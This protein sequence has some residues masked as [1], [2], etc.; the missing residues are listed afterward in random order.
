MSMIKRL[1]T[2]LLLLF[3]LSILYSVTPVFAGVPLGCG[4]IGG[5]SSGDDCTLNANYNCVAITEID[6]PG[7]FT[8][9]NGF[10][11]N[12]N[13]FN[14]TID[15]GGDFIVNGTVRTDGADGANPAD[16]STPGANGANGANGSGSTPPVA[17]TNGTAGNNGMNGGNATNPGT[18]NI[19][20]DGAF[21]VGMNGSVSAE[22][23]DGGKGGKGCD[24]GNGGTG[25][26]GT[27]SS[28]ARNGANGGNGAVGGTGGSAGTC[29]VGGT[30]NITSGTS[31]S[32]GDIYLAGSISTNGGKGGNGGNGGKG[33][34]GGAGGNEGATGS[35]DGNGG[36]G[37]NG[38]NGGVGG[39]ASSG[40]SAGEINFNEDFILTSSG[41]INNNGGVG[42]N[43]GTGGAGGNGANGG[44]AQGTN[45]VNGTGGNGGNGGNGAN[46]ANGANGG[47]TTVNSSGDVDI[48]GTIASILGAK[49]SKGNGGAKGIK[50][51]NGT[52]ATGGGTPVD[53]M[54]GSGGA[55]GSAGT[56]DGMNTINYCDTASL[57]KTGSTITPADTTVADSGLCKTCSLEFDKK[58]IIKPSTAG[59]VIFDLDDFCDEETGLCA[60]DGSTDC[61]SNGDADCRITD[62]AVG[63]NSEDVE[64]QFC[65]NNTGDINLVNGTITDTDVDSTTVVTTFETIDIEAGNSNCFTYPSPDP[66]V[67]DDPSDIEGVDMGDLD[68]YCAKSIAPSN[69]N[70]NLTVVMKSDEAELD[71]QTPG[72]N[73]VKS[74]DLLS[75]ETELFE[76]D[77]TATNTGTAKLIN[78]YLKDVVKTGQCPQAADFD[79]D[80]TTVET[81]IGMLDAGGVGSQFQMI[82]DNTGAGY[83]I[84]DESCNNVQVI[85]NV[86][87]GKGSPALD[88]SGVPIEVESTF[89]DTCTPGVA[90]DVTRGKGFYKVHKALLSS[91]FDQ[92]GDPFDLGFLECNDLSCLL[93]IYWTNPGQFDIPMKRK[94][95]PQDPKRDKVCSERIKLAEQYI[96]AVCNHELF[97]S[98]PDPAG[99]DL[100][101]ALSA[102]AGTNLDD[103]KDCR[104]DLQEFNASGADLPFPDI[105]FEGPATPGTAKDMAVDSTTPANCNDN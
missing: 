47:N 81:L 77:I 102:L 59:E 76:F 101:E 2:T 30:V 93:G 33:G 82:Y 92:V 68:I 98:S 75:G 14:L 26:N 60:D 8:I 53:G 97:G 43:G 7:D 96:S 71:C 48:E 69:P 28:G 3:T 94:G 23:G 11:I 79:T 66:A 15:V 27:S 36:N 87:N 105:S 78:C 52:G 24:G 16:C 62:F 9:S 70:Q 50:G 40:C 37:G 80:P 54:D 57:D 58:I 31:S 104:M 49:G 39:S 5:T 42:G 1:F 91:C 20:V 4:G 38:A 12:C 99:C 6:I 89:D 83:N 41:S 86:D 88:D 18:L 84:P 65:I 32:F 21:D 55:D 34:N 13:G 72:L 10:T 103:I 64:F 63:W 56:S 100:S 17:G 74:C 51:T 61:S 22:G 85:C 67:C 46:G 45:G 95:K 19:N 73:V 44:D 25:G 90:S 29:T 35:N